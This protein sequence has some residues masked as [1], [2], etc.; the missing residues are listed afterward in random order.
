MKKRILKSYLGLILSLLICHSIQAQSISIIG[1]LEDSIQQQDLQG[2]SVFLLKEKDSVLLYATIAQKNGKF[3]FRNISTGKFIIQAT[4][5]GYNTIYK[6][7]KLNNQ[8]LVNVGNIKM[9]YNEDILQTV[10]VDANVPAIIAKKDTLEYNAPSFKTR[11][12]ATVEDLLRLL[13]GIQV[14][15]DGKIIANGKEIQQVLVD[16]KI[17]FGGSTTM[18][19]KNLPAEIINKVQVYTASSDNKNF[20]GIEDGQRTNTLNLQIKQNR[21]HGSFGNIGAGGGIKKVYGGSANYNIFNN[22]R[23]LS[24]IGQITNVNNPIFNTTISLPNASKNGISTARGAGANLRDKLGKNIDL[25]GSYIYSHQNTLLNIN[26]T[27]QNIFPQDSSTFNLNSSIAKSANNTHRINLN[28]E[29]RINKNNRLTIKPNLIITDLYSDVSRTSSL[30]QN[31]I[32]RTE[33]YNSTQRA[34]TKKAETNINS[35]ISF[36]HKFKKPNRSINLTIDLYNNHSNFNN[37][38][39]SLNSYNQP[40]PKEDTL[41]QKVVGKNSSS[42]F[43][44]KI[45]YSEPLTSNQNLIFSYEYQY[46]KDENNLRTSRYNYSTDQYSILDSAQSNIFE[47]TIRNNTMGLMYQLI[48]TKG[49]LTLEAKLA[50]QQV[51]NN[52]RSKGQ[53]NM[54]KYNNIIPNISYN[55]LLSEGKSIQLNYSLTPQ[56]PSINQLQPTNITRDSL[57]IYKGNPN[58][59]Q[60]KIHNINLNY[61]N[62][63]FKTQKTLSYNLSANIFSKYIGQSIDNLPNGAQIFSPINIDGTYNINSYVSYGM[64]LKKMHTNLTFT[65]NISYN[66][67]KSMLNDKTLDQNNVNISQGINGALNIPNKIMFNISAISSYVIS[68][69]ATQT[70]NSIKYFVQKF[71]GALNIYLPKRITFSSDYDISY[72]GN[73]AKGFAKWLPLISPGISKEIFRNG[74]GQLKLYIYDLFN[75]GINITRSVTPNT[76][77]TSLNNA[78]SRYLMLSFSYRFKRFKH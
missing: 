1:T 23:Q 35:Y 55:K 30:S 61:Q 76:I 54:Y 31:K 62:N 39:Y 20:T 70:S 8:L 38:L 63:S 78:R 14:T 21:R 42:R 59:K 69:Y 48:S 73:I 72:N 28:F 12:N 34:K 68:S 26:N 16:N 6:S 19:T 75:K 36:A 51:K 29:D 37:K 71:S 11:P 57:F 77:M 17:F 58:L 53:I 64:L 47:N 41:N 56:L 40:Y 49:N 2:A 13:P 67:Y 74:Q 44:P 66:K 7:I 27:I 52:D 33:I 22:D 65:N 46:S 25:Y 3:K 60:T 45:I 18:A 24:F 32:N 5:K 10:K 4:F 9:T 43:N 15:T 50:N